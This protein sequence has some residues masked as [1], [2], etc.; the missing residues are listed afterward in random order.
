ME[1]SLTRIAECINRAHDETEYVT[2][3]LENMV[4]AFL[5]NQSATSC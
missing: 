1:E 4:R 3:V 2:I 5:S